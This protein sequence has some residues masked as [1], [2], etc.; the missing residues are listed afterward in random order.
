[1]DVDSEAVR[2]HLRRLELQEGIAKYLARKIAALTIEKRTI[3]FEKADFTLSSTK[4]FSWRRN[5]LPQPLVADHTVFNYVAT[6]N[7]FC[8][9][10]PLVPGKYLHHALYGR[11]VPNG[12]SVRPYSGSGPI[13]SCAQSTG[14]AGGRCLGHAR[15]GACQYKATTI[16]IAERVADWIKEDK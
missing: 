10:G 1:V 13:R 3:E 5:L 9:L 7:D 2:T 11:D 14:P 6:Y 16:M 15:C 4:P 8:G 12:A